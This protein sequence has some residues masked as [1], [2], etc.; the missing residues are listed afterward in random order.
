MK[1]NPADHDTITLAA[2]VLTTA[3]ITDNYILNLSWRAWDVLVQLLL[4]G[5][6]D[7]EAGPYFSVI[8]A[9]IQYGHT[10]RIETDGSGDL[11]SSLTPTSLTAPSPCSQDSEMN[12]VTVDWDDVFL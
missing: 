11:S 2:L 8:H 9:V 7:T 1:I 6:S 10:L 3:H 5:E 4:V 12:D